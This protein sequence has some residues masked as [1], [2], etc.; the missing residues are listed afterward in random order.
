MP[1]QDYDDVFADDGWRDLP[2]FPDLKGKTV[3]IMGGGSGIGAYYAAAFSLQGANVGFIS[4]LEEP[5]TILC[6]QI[7]EKTGLRPLSIVGDIRDLDVLRDSIDKVRNQFGPIDVLINNAARDTR[8]GLEDYSEA[9]WDDSINTNLRPHYFSIQSVVKDM[10]AQG[11]GSIINISSVSYNLGLAGYPAYVAAKGAIMGLTK[12][13]GRELGPKNI[14]VNAIAPGWV[15][16][17]RQNRL[18]VNDETVQDTLSKQSIKQSLIGWD[19]VGTA[20]FLAS[21]SSSKICGQEI[22]VDGGWV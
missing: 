11:G 13:L 19:M 20:L 21:K 4:L 16:T 14:R 6:N 9:E 15:L 2:T 5:A 10:E 12:A 1:L 7:E 18:W 8:H 17:E 22:I 3:Y